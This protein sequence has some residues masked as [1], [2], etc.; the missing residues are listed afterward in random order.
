[1]TSTTNTTPVRTPAPPIPL[2]PTDGRFAA[3]DAIDV[4]A[5]LTEALDGV[6]LDRADQALLETID[7]HPHGTGT[8]LLAGVAALIARA[9]HTG[10]TQALAELV[11]ETA[12]AELTDKARKAGYAAGKADA[13]ATAQAQAAVLAAERDTADEVA[14]ARRSQ[15][16]KELQDVLSN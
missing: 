14:R 15:A 6:E 11:G 2:A 12:A 4:Q 1:M 7:Q 9:R 16:W 10:R 3:R 5:W 13:E 8:A